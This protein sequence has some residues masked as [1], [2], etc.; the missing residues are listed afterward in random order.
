MEHSVTVRRM[1]PFPRTLPPLREHVRVEHGLVLPS[2]LVIIV[3]ASRR[4]T[5]RARPVASDDAPPPPHDA[6]APVCPVLGH[7][8]GAVHP[9]PPA[10]MTGG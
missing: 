8:V 9:R 7:L 6:V 3:D 1:Q 4:T 2:I 5:A 10:R